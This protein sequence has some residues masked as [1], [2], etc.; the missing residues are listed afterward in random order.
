MPAAVRAMTHSVLM[1]VLKVLAKIIPIPKPTLFT[2]AGSAFDLCSAIAQMGTRKLLI[3]TDTVLVRIGLLDIVK[4]ALDQNGVQY[5]IYDGVEPDPNYDQVEDGFAMLKENDCNAVLAV[6]GGSCIDAAKIISAL[7]TN[8]KSVRKMVGW[9]KIRKACLPLYVIPTTAGTGSEVAAV[10]ADYHTVTNLAELTDMIAELRA[11]GWFAFDTE[12]TGLFPLQATIRQL[13]GQYARRTELR[14]LFVRLLM[15]VSLSKNA[16]QRVERNILWKI[17][18]ELDISRVELAQVEA[19]LRAQRG[20]RR[21]PHGDTDAANVSRAYG[22][23]GIDQAATNDEVKKAYRRLM[24]KHHPDKI[25]ASNPDAAVL[26]E[27]ERH[28]RKIRS[29]YDLLKTRRSM[30]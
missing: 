25:A 23:L 5:A 24:N 16:L 26:D 4:E 30:R 20:F 28:T 11:A 3:V 13:R 7:A 14:S 9:F 1:S 12:T 19:M 8:K 6:G 27:A 21:S 18:K 22:T 2:G 10:E 17:C 15:E 29:A